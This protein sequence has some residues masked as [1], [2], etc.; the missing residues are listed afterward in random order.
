MQLVWFVFW[1]IGLTCLFNATGNCYLVLWYNSC[2]CF[3]VF[4]VV[5]YVTAPLWLQVTAQCGAKADTRKIARI[6][7]MMCVVSGRTQRK[8]VASQLKSQLQ[9][10]KVTID[11]YPGSFARKH[12]HWITVVSL[13]CHT[14]SMFPTKFGVLVKVRD[15]VMV[16]AVASQMSE[17]TRWKI[18]MCSR[19]SHGSRVHW[20]LFWR[21]SKWWRT[22]SRSIKDSHGSSCKWCVSWR[23]G[24]NVFPCSIFDMPLSE[25]RHTGLASVSGCRDAGCVGLSVPS[26][27]FL[28]TMGYL[29]E[30]TLRVTS[31]TTPE[32]HLTTKPIINSN[33]FQ[34]NRL[35]L[36]M[37]HDNSQ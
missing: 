4:D 21:W 6:S 34:F 20:T 16:S 12:P 15:H 27:S 2:A 26:S 23:R 3:F 5:V 31:M 37:Q 7:R 19:T 30:I 14:L 25:P 8:I 18:S 35:S 33:L 17:E 36:A 28:H 24:C 9:A 13:P 10:L 1:T 11:H 29:A 32:K 22:T